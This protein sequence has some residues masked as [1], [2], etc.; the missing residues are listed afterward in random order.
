MECH[1]RSTFMTYGL[2]DLMNAPDAIFARDKQ[3]ASEADRMEAAV[4][5]SKMR[6]KWG[7]TP[8]KGQQLK[9]RG[10]LGYL[11]LPLIWR[12]QTFEGMS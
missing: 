8:F 10:A 2:P 1:N 11:L 12:G 9:I 5:E 7:Q 6:V 4:I 3:I